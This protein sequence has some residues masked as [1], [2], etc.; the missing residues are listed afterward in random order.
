MSKSALGVSGR[1]LAGA[2]ILTSVAACTSGAAGDSCLEREAAGY[3]GMEK[4]AAKVLRGTD[5]TMQRVGQCAD[6]G[7]PW[8]T[9]EARVRGW[10]YRK[11]ALRQLERRGWVKEQNDVS[12]DG[13]FGPRPCPVAR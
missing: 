4:A 6:S 5:F 13:A 10:T 1:L 11:Q 12:P 3:L 8:T 2:V 7:Q 9:L